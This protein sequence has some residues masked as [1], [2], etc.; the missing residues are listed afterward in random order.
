MKIVA[1]YEGGNWVFYRGTDVL[2]RVSAGMDREMAM[3]VVAALN[4]HD[5]LLAVAKR[6]VKAR[7]DYETYDYTLSTENVKAIAS[8]AEAAIDCAAVIVEER[9]SIGPF[10]G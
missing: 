5:A 8:D 1:E 6:L 10:H 7:K 3:E 4:S 9:I 2:F